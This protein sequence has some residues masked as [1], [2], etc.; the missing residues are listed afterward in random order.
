MIRLNKNF[1]GSEFGDLNEENTVVPASASVKP[2]TPV[3]AGK[4]RIC[5]QHKCS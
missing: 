3:N 4:I 5:K 1:V 2:T